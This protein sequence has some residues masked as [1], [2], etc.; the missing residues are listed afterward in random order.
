M[1]TQMIIDSH[2]YHRKD[3]GELERIDSSL[4]DSSEGMLAHQL[5]P[6]VLYYIRI[7]PLH[8]SPTKLF[9]AYNTLFSLHLPGIQRPCYLKETAL[10]SSHELYFKPNTPH[11]E[12]E[13]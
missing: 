2:D 9:A 4:A 10:S 5:L 1:G 11:C 12:V 3:D 7:L 6:V 8:P 13:C